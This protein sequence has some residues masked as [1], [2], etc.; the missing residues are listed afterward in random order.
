M[1]KTFKIVKMVSEADTGY[2]YTTT[3]P[4]R[5][6]KASVKLRQKR[7]DPVIMKHCWFKEVKKL[8]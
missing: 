2:Y 4:M 1:A 3:R 8:K 7:Y 6:L 5:G